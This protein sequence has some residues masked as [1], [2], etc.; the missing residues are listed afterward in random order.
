MFANAEAATIRNR[1]PWL[2]WL[3]MAALIAVVVQAFWTAHLERVARQTELVRSTQIA[4]QILRLA[5]ACRS[6]FDHATG[7][8]AAIVRGGR[9]EPGPEAAWLHEAPSPL[10]DD[11]VV[12]DRL[13]RAAKAEFADKDA[14][15][16]ARGFDTLLA[17]PLLAC[18]RLVVLAAAAWQAQRSGNRERLGALLERLDAEIE[19]LAPSDLARPALARATAAA[20]RLP[21]SS[22]PAWAQRLA[23]FLPQSATVG[24]LESWSGSQTATCERR[25]ELLRIERAIAAAPAFA[26]ATALCATPEG[27][28]WRMANDDGSIA[29]VVVDPTRFLAAAVH[30]GE[31][32]A[33]PRWPWLVEAVLW[34]GSD[35]SA[36]AGCA[37]VPFVRA[38]RESGD[39]ALAEQ[40][41][42]WPFA[43]V[44]LVLAFAAALRAQRRAA[45]REA[46]AVDAQ[47]EFLTNVTHELK[48]PL[49]SIR[50]LAEMLQEGR[51]K[52]R[53]H[54]YHAMLGAESAR[55]ST[56]LENVLDL[57]RTERGERTFDVRDFDLAFAAREATALLQPLVARDGRSITLRTD[58]ATYARGDR[59]AVTQALV[60]LIDNARKYGS[61]PIEVEA[62]A[63][64][65]SASIEVRDCGEGVPVVERERIFERF[66]RGSRHRHGATPGTGIGLYVARATLRRLG[67]DIVCAEPFQGRGARFVLTL[68]AGEPA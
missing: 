16:A 49:A 53:E 50:L 39:Y 45:L 31:S 1:Q 34:D 67:G 5:P 14:Q 6:A 40:T 62:R 36:V 20:L 29:A 24:L 13:A 59:D 11:A 9:L 32:G 28:L 38:L 52:G 43:T 2:T 4:E 68:P 65:G 64:D 37:G 25:A 46:A 54:E 61:G 44:A 23:P 55:L 58:S 10:D 48:T 3:G 66:V 17:G 47:S 26:P 18:Q 33:L 35:A 63:L 7:G 22:P 57:G 51:A 60:A 19:A 21:R 42:L 15:L 12:E 30:A 56:L 27:P 8:R 41:G